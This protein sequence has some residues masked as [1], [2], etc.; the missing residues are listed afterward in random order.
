MI[1]LVATVQELEL[2]KADIMA[3]ADDVER[4]T[5]RQARRSR[6]AR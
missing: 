2:V 6:S 1:P 3:V 5:G 4:E